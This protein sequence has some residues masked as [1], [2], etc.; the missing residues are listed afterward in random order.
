MWNAG[1]DNASWKE[2]CQ[3]KYQ[4]PLICKQYQS[5]GRKWRGAKKPLDENERRDRESWL[6]IQHQKSKDHGVWSHPFT[7]NRGESGNSDRFYFLGLQ[8]HCGRWLQPWNQK[9]LAPWKETYDKPRQHIKKQRRHLPTKVHTV[10]AMDVR[11]RRKWQ[12]TPVF[13]PGESCGQTS[14]VGC[15][16]WG[17]TESDTTEAT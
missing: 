15:R 11:W 7:A 1:L 16:L 10:K 5:Y 12:P 3:E 14:L 13:L 8:N 2:D 6:E 4:Q 9:M 17:R